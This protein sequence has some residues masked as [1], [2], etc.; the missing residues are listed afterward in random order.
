MANSFILLV[1]TKDS[2]KAKYT[3]SI[4]RAFVKNEKS[5]IL[6][7][8]SVIAWVFDF[9]KF[10]TITDVSLQAMCIACATI[11][12]LCSEDG[13]IH[14]R[15]TKYLVPWMW[16]RFRA[17]FC[18]ISPI[19]LPSLA[20]RRKRQF[21]ERKTQKCRALACLA[22]AI[23]DTFCAE[24]DGLI[25]QFPLLHPIYHYSRYALDI[26]IFCMSFWSFDFDFCQ[27]YHN[28]R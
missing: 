8:A 22:I 24:F 23:T 2:S 18:L 11:A 13:F 17:F 7:Y 5:K 4:G 9:R 6:Q 1:V 26:V 12:S 20:N 15:R 28:T 19:F 10:I 3:S 16:S 14:E 27:S 25:F 21:V